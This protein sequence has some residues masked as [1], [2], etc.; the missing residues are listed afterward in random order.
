MLPAT[1]AD[2]LGTRLL[3]LHGDDGRALVEI[4]AELEQEV[5]REPRNLV[6]ATAYAHALRVGG[7]RAAAN[8]ETERCY[9][10]WR[11]LPAVSPG[12]TLNVATSLT[13][14]RMLVEAKRVMSTLE[15]RPLETH[16]QVRLGH[17]VAH[18]ALRYGE[19]EW[20]AARDPAQPVLAYLL[21]H[22]LASRWSAQ[23]QAVDALMGERI[24]SASWEILGL[25]E[26]NA[27]CLA[28]DYF[29]DDTSYAQIEAL[30]TGLWDVVE[31]V[32]GEH[33][34]LLVQHVTFTVYGPQVPLE[35]MKP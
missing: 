1:K 25:G 8:A 35:G 4:I 14:A 34:P 18:L 24:L 5:R 16:E 23:Q 27:Y 7:L 32:W 29:T 13:D 12:M 9:Q 3:S 21:H 20:L 17:L 31:G 19:L 30:Q 11:R 26:D 33:L 22:Q 6:A 10:M 2:H 28:V 15:G